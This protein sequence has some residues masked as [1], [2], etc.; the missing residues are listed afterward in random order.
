ML[1][2]F[3]QKSTNFFMTGQMKALFDLL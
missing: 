3:F 1:G 2:S